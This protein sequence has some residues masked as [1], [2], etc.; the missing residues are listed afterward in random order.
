MAGMHANY[1]ISPRV[2]LEWFQGKRT[3]LQAPDWTQW[4]DNTV[5]EFVESRGLVAHMFVIVS[6]HLANLSQAHI[7]F[8]FSAMSKPLI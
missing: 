6:G 4:P 2:V 8:P 3:N 5:R 1:R 7:H